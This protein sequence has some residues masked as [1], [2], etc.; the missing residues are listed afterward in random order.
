MKNVTIREIDLDISEKVFFDKIKN[1][2]SA[3]LFSGVNC[4]IDLIRKSDIAPQLSILMVS[5]WQTL[6]AS[7]NIKSKSYI[8]EQ[9][10]DNQQ[11]I[12]LFIA[13][14]VDNQQIYFGG[15]Y[16]N[17]VHFCNSFIRNKAAP[18]T[19]KNLLL[20]ESADRITTSGTDS[21]AF[22]KAYQKLVM[23]NALSLE[24]LKTSFNEFFEEENNKLI[25]NIIKKAQN[26]KFKKEKLS[27]NTYFLKSVDST[28]IKLHKFNYSFKYKDIIKLEHEC[29]P[30]TYNCDIEKNEV[31]DYI[32]S[33]SYVLEMQENEEFDIICSSAMHSEY[34]FPGIYAFIIKYSEHIRYFIVPEYSVPIEMSEEVFKENLSYLPVL[35]AEFDRLAIIEEKTYINDSIL[36]SD[37]IKM[38][39]YKI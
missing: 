38:P 28:D 18:S 31:T 21:L 26:F 36:I 27:D 9:L 19:F 25:E 22:F 23:N 35:K 7:K 39:I 30:K 15:N 3:L 2:E 10:N 4:D 1:L 6:E 12:S 14:N 20:Y 29:Y 37:K 8:L 13:T 16:I 33:I 17:F 32:N 24:N 5:Y 11:I 34:N